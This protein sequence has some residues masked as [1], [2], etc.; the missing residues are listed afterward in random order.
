MWKFLTRIFRKHTKICHECKSSINVN[1][2]AALCLQFVDEGQ[3]SELYVCEPCAERLWLESLND[4][5]F[6]ELRIAEED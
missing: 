6:E 2:D 1:K 5:M 4:D 3:V